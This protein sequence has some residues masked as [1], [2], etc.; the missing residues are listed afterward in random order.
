LSLQQTLD[1][2]CERKN[3]PDRDEYFSLL[4]RTITVLEHEDQSIRPPDSSLLSGGLVRLKTG[5]PTLLLPDLHARMD[6][7][8]DAMRYSPGDGSTVLDALESG[9]LQLICLGDGFH[10]ER[11]AYQRWINALREY[12]HGYARHRAMDAE[13][14]ECFGLMEMVMLVKCAFRDHVHFLKGNHENILNEEG[15][16]NHPFRKF[17]F[18]GEMV[19]EY[20]L[21]FFDGEFIQMYSLFEKSL[22]VIAVGETFI[23]SHAEPQHPFAEADLIEARFRPDVILSLTWTDNGD[24]D[25]DSVASM[26]DMFLPSVSGAVYFGGHRPVQGGFG[27]R[28][29]GKYI[30]IHNPEM[31]NVTLVPAGRIFD[32]AT[33]IREVTQGKG[34]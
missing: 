27:S 29:N 17:A 15:N 24:A 2:I 21:K 30:Q 4:E 23:A 19:K 6:F 9:E 22:P 16:G 12:D 1:A 32:P 5:I 20:V 18:E 33:D 34:K 25:E 28:A 10:S 14:R 8:S 7:F 31:K 26:L 11:R 13:M 3:L